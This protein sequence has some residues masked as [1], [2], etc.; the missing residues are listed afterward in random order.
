MREI[1]IWSGILTESEVRRD[2]YLQ[3][4]DLVHQMFSKHSKCTLIG[5]WP[6]NRLMSGPWPWQGSLV[7]CTSHLEEHKQNSVHL[8]I[9]FS[10]LAWHLPHRRMLR[11]SMAYCYG[12]LYVLVGILLVSK[13]V[14]C[15]WGLLWRSLWL[16]IVLECLLLWETWQTRTTTYV[17]VH[18]ATRWRIRHGFM[19]LWFKE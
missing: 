19:L 1:R 2:M 17:E 3:R 4:I 11:Y 12:V 10:C 15:G 8:R 18:T 6:M 5:Y 13:E 9:V 16:L 7:S 14:N